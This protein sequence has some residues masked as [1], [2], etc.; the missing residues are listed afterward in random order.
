MGVTRARE[1]ATAWNEGKVR[2]ATVVQA[3]LERCS[4]CG[5]GDGGDNGEK[6]GRWEGI[7]LSDAFDVADRARVAVADAAGGRRL[8]QRVVLDEIGRKLASC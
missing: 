8:Q 3:G 7:R 5:L 2:G 4:Q 1:R 6:K